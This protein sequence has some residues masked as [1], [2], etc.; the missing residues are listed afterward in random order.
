MISVFF[1]RLYFIGPFLLV[2]ESTKW[3]Y[4][5]MHLQSRSRFNTPSSLLLYTSE[6]HGNPAPLLVFIL[7]HVRCHHCLTSSVSIFY[8][9][10]FSEPLLVL[11]EY[12]PFG[13]LLGY[14]RKS[15]GLNDT[16]YKDPDIK[17]KT[18]LTSQQLMKFAWQIADGMSY[19]SSK[20]VR[21][22]LSCWA[23]MFSAL[24]GLLRNSSLWLRP[25]AY[26][27]SS[28]VIAL[29]VGKLSQSMNLK[30]A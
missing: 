22:A 30:L 10:F 1:S 28:D 5:C 18:S 26:T 3:I 7:V 19:L 21:N 8:L 9:V 4:K 12:V 13:D 23:F 25:L 16:Y 6:N 14:L 15:R 29:S 11:I 24:I 2:V 17:P 20:R 27:F